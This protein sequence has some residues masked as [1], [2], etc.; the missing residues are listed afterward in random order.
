MGVGGHTGAASGSVFLDLS[1]LL[2][3]GVVEVGAPSSL[4][5]TTV[6]TS[7]QSCDVV[8]SCPLYEYECEEQIPE[9]VIG[10]HF[11]LSDVTDPL[12]TL[13]ES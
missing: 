13:S 11:I 6:G 7:L 1:T 2:Y 4:S 3:T 9:Q 5:T 12:L 10:L 8:L